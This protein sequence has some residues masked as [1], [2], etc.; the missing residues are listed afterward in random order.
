VPPFAG[1]QPFFITLVRPR[2]TGRITKACKGFLMANGNW[3][4][5]KQK[6]QGRRNMDLG[7]H[8]KMDGTGRNSI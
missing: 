8:R 4:G 5:T 6:K 7:R 1:N 3:D 2:K